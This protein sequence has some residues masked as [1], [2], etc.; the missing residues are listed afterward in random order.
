MRPLAGDEDPER[1]AVDL[2]EFDLE[3]LEIQ[4]V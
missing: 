1:A 3:D 4:A 2:V